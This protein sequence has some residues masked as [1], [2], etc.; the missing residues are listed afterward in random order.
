MLYRVIHTGRQAHVLPLRIRR[1]PQKVLRRSMSPDDMQ[2]RND[3]CGVRGT[4]TPGITPSDSFASREG[5]KSFKA[6]Q[7]ILSGWGT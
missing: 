4:P 1:Y 2:V 5:L 3:L 6:I 7:L